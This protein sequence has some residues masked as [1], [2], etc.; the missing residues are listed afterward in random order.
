MVDEVEV[1]LEVAAAM[2]IG[3]VVGPRE[4]TYSVVCHQWFCGGVSASRTLPTT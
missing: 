4:V 2:G 1:D 3:E